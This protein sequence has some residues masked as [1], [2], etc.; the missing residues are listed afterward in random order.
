MSEAQT[1]HF[2]RIAGGY[3]ATIPAHV[4]DHYLRKRAAVIGPLLHEGEG[5][6]VGCGTGLLMEAL[7][8]FGKVVGVDSSEGMLDVLRR[9]GRGEA[10]CAPSDALPFADG[11]FDVVFSV[12]VLHHVAAPDAVRKTL[13]EM[14]RVAKKPGGRIV[15]WD[16]NPRN[17]YW[18]VLM[19]R[20]PQDTGAERLIPDDEI[21]AALR[22]AGVKEIRLMR[23]GFVPD[24]IPR[25]LMP[26]AAL[27]EYVLEKT[28]LLRNFTA[29]NVVFAET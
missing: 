14:V 1:D 7:K 5:L 21:I 26:L 17:P 4:R 23:S 27:G 13:T 18:P 3:D 29:H 22:S 24:F 25:A 10:V 15:I 6:D 9:M 12:A 16:H 8:P 28:P 2:D 11:R 19:R 20:V